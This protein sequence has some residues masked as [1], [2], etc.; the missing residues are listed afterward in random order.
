MPTFALT[1][2]GELIRMED[3]S[4]VLLSTPTPLRESAFVAIAS[5][6]GTALPTWPIE[7]NRRAPVD[8]ERETLPRLVLRDGSHRVMPS[9]AFG[10]RLYRV[11]IAI[12][13]WVKAGSDAELG[14][15]LNDAH[16][17]IVGA[18]CDVELPV[19]GDEQA[20][21]PEELALQAEPLSAAGS[22]IRA[23]SFE[24]A[25]GF[26]LRVADTGAPYTTT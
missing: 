20:I 21:S 10:L 7:R 8:I 19:D 14:Y 6:L 25:I 24:L 18:I 23:M 3:G 11:E 13:G 1:E 17:Q 16:A 2:S 5:R 26:N 9:D 12:E 15:A 4:F 22:K